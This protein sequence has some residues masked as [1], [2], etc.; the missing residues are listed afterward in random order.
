MGWEFKDDRPIYLQLID[1]LQL[2]IISGIYKT[3]DKLPSV[4]ELASEASVN[5]NT[6]QKALTELERKNLVFTQRT[7]GRFIT[8]DI[9][10]INKIR[11][12]LAK[13]EI[14]SFLNNMKNIGYDQNEIIN[15]MDKFM[16]EM[17]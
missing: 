2:R 15:I 7:S 17:K 3:G 16:K 13:K 11:N 10:L 6:M 4:R 9:D 5:P 8:E 14:E 12:D 1:Q